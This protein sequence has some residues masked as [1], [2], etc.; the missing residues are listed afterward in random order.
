[1]CIAIV[2]KAGAVLTKDTLHNCYL[3]N[4]DGCGF[5]YVNTDVYGEKRVRIKKS[6]DFE[7]FYARYSKAVEQNPNSTFLIHFR[8]ATHGMIDK[9]NCHPFQINKEQAFIHNGIIPNMPNDGKGDH[10][11]DTRIFKDRILR[12]LPSGWDTNPAVKYMIEAVI[13]AS[14]LAVLNVDNTF[15]IFKEASG[16]WKDDIWY[17]NNSYTYKPY[18]VM[19][20]MKGYL[21]HI[22]AQHERSRKEYKEKREAKI[23]GLAEKVDSSTFIECEWCSE[24]I[25]K[26]TAKRMGMDG[27]E[28]IC[29]DDCAAMLAKDELFN[30][31]PFNNAIYL[32]GN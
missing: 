21:D 25:L 5:A 7:T 30:A 2:K 32:R 10:R 28:V 18:S 3:N 20:H 9:Y 22:D 19:K 6:M 23:F 16:H 13:G 29:C 11:S 4:K 8:I 31:T 24:Y 17:S 15:S 12:R 1:M 14:K 26:K 27:M